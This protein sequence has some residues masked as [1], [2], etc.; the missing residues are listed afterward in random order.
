[1]KNYQTDIPDLLANGI[2]VMI[3]AGGM[4]LF[5]ALFSGISLLTA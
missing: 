2:R 4:S 1:M 3:Y 5:V